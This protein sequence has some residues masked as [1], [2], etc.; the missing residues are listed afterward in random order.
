MCGLC[1]VWVCVY[2][3][4]VMC[5]CVDNLCT[6]I[7][8]VL[9]CLY[10]VF[11]LFRLCFVCTSVRTKDYCH[12]VTTQSQLVAEAAFEGDKWGDRPRPCSWGGP[13]LQASDVDDQSTLE[14]KQIIVFNLCLHVIWKMT[15]IISLLGQRLVVMLLFWFKKPL[16][17]NRKQFYEW[18]KT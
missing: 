12:R 1:N 16:S 17:T 2:V 8:C 3:G 13:A 6:C 15:I 10:C 9:Y 7:Y 5:G 14:I 11:V 4:F 18:W